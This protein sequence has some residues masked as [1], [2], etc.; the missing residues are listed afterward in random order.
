MDCMDC[1]YHNCKEITATYLCSILQ[2]F[3]SNSQR[4][5]ISKSER[6]LATIWRQYGIVER[7]D[8]EI[9]FWVPHIVLNKSRTCLITILIRKKFIFIFVP[10]THRISFEDKW[11]KCI[12]NVICKYLGS[13]SGSAT[14]FSY[15]G[16]NI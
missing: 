16:Q 7:A 1:V 2:C 9:W 4:Q 13:N 14:D 15:L 3:Q 11:E 12:Q 8:F 5:G 10:L 6:G